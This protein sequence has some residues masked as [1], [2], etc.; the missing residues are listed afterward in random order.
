[1]PIL[2]ILIDKEETRPVV[3][4]ALLTFYCYFAEIQGIG[5]SRAN[6]ASTY[7]ATLRFLWFSQGITMCY[8]FYP[9]PPPTKIRGSTLFIALDQS[10]SF[11]LWEVNIVDIFKHKIPTE[12]QLWCKKKKSLNPSSSCWLSPVWL[13]KPCFTTWIIGFYM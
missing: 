4:V 12:R 5:K 8:I 9:P 2:L 7:W 10:I 3:L 1:M 13:W 11:I 6:S